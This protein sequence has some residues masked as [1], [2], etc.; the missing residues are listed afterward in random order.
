MLGFFGVLGT[1]RRT[2]ALRGWVEDSW[3]LEGCAGG[4][5]DLVWR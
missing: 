1:V 5:R 4:L 2:F 3:G